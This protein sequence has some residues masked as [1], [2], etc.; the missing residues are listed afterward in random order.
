MELVLFSG[1]H[2][3]ANLIKRAAPACLAV[4]FDYGQEA[5]LKEMG[6]AIS[7]CASFSVPLKIEQ[8]PAV[9]T[10]GD[11]HY[12]RNLLMIA[13]AVPIAMSVGATTIQIGCTDL[14]HDRFPD[15][16]PE[17]IESLS[18]TTEA[19]YG[20][21]VTAPLVSRPTYII[22]GTWSCYGGDSRPCGACRSCR[23]GYHA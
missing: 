16:R 4:F 13:L 11:L 14:D 6:A 1:G 3:S 19:A 5:R 22:P 15:C 10:E 18:A 17:F 7:I 21:R 20:V 8:M 9:E 12:G 2:D 23:Q